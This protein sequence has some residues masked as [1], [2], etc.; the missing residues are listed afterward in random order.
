MFI[1]KYIQMWRNDNFG[2]SDKMWKISGK[3]DKSKHWQQIRNNISSL[4]QKDFII[5]IYI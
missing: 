5:Y 1:Y 2:E 4:F 3:G